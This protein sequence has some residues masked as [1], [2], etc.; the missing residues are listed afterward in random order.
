MKSFTEINGRLVSVEIEHVYPPIPIR[1]S[2]YRAWYTSDESDN[3]DSGWG[4]TPEDAIQDLVDSYDD[5][6]APVTFE[7]EYDCELVIER[8]HVNAYEYLYFQEASK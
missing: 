8:L 1:T 4:A 7:S 2:D 5:P 6:E 3:P